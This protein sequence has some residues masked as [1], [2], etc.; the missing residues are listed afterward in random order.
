MFLGL[1][2]LKSRSILMVGL[3]AIAQYF[4][5]SLALPKTDKSKE[6]SGPERMSKQMVLFGPLFTI[7]VL[8]QLPSAL[9][10]YWLIT[11]VFS[12]VQQIYINKKVRITID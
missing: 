10:I 8:W 11:S 6:L 2:D 1:I 4:Q 5:G 9:G 7:L 3:A 12:I